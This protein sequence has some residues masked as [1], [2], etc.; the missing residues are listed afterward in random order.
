M[1]FAEILSNASSGNS[2]ISSQSFQLLKK[3][4]EENTD[5]YTL[6]LFS[7]FQNHN[8]DYHLCCNGLSL[9]CYNS[10]SFDM[11]VQNYQL[12]LQFLRSS[13]VTLNNLAIPPLSALLRMI[14]YNG[15]P[16][17]SEIINTFIE[18]L[19]DPDEN[20]ACNC[21]A[22]ICQSYNGFQQYA[23]MLF[24]PL[25]ESLS[26]QRPI[27]QK[28]I[29]ENLSQID[30]E[31]LNII[32]QFPNYIQGITSFFND[33]S[34]IGPSFVFL[35]S[36]FSKKSS[37]LTQEISQ[38]ILEIDIQKIQNS[39][40]VLKLE[41]I[42]LWSS[43]AMAEKNAGEGEMIP[44]MS[45]IFC[46]EIVT[47]LLLNFSNRRDVEE[48]E[49]NTFDIADASKK[50]LIMICENCVQQS[51]PLLLSFI[52]ENINENADSTMN[53]LH[54]F[55]KLKDEERVE[56]IFDNIIEWILSSFQHQ[57]K[58]ARL[59]GL[60]CLT[61]LSL[62]FTFVTFEMI[63]SL[64]ENVINLWQDDDENVAQEA[65]KC[66][67]YIYSKAPWFVIVD[68]SQSFIDLLQYISVSRLNFY[69][70]F[71]SSFF[72]QCDDMDDMNRILEILVTLC[73]E[74]LSQNEWPNQVF[75][76]IFGCLYKLCSSKSDKRFSEELISSIFDISLVA[77]S[78]KS[79]DDALLL[80]SFLASAEPVL[81]AEN[82]RHIRL[83]HFIFETFDKN[84]STYA[85][86][87]LSNM[88]LTY[89]DLIAD[90]NE[91][92]QKIISIV[93][94]SISYLN[95]EQKIEYLKYSI[96][97][98]TIL[99][100]NNLP[101]SQQISEF[102]F[103]SLDEAATQY[104]LCDVDEETIFAANIQY[105]TKFAVHT[106]QINNYCNE[107]FS[108]MALSVTKLYS[109][110]HCC[111]NELISEMK[112]MAELIMKTLDLS[113]IDDEHANFLEITSEF[114]DT[115]DI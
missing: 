64:V 23:E 97:I 93:F 38:K 26:Q 103:S 12:I 94:D 43:I 69:F 5:E 91:E 106:F 60:K 74:A 113:E 34:L 62:K 100:D 65:Y 63:S 46:N 76:A 6:Q 83:I 47:F 7:I 72:S 11:F 18:G 66:C 42:E 79:V 115:H 15:N 53:V 3:F 45:S 114:T 35:S 61:T 89:D 22:V 32:K 67:S 29:L 4:A 56:E 68:Q 98:M 48:G 2:E 108:S 58:F 78:E 24:T 96:P 27:L 31:D 10:I 21:V 17:S 86:S 105:L 90:C 57:N 70:Q 30:A 99:V 59:A 107:L 16:N 55:L 85:L 110:S 101:I 49:I 36:V 95:F 88:I 82:N 104:C 109:R 1:D 37:F 20:Y 87:A 33:D 13:D 102:V 51:I 92:L 111:P 75:D 54:V 81:F 77:Y 39:D 25:F 84:V 41:F 44:Q 71:L 19:Q 28:K 73:S 14:L 8:E 9:I 50:C 52:S 112:F 80:P 40:D